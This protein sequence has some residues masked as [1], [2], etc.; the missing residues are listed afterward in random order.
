MAN[1]FVLTAALQLQAPRN[2]NA[3]A[4]AIQNRL[5]NISTNVNIRINANASRNINNINRSITALNATLNTFNQQSSAA[6]TNVTAL[7]NAFRG[8]TSNLNSLNQT[9]T[10]TTRSL[11]GVRTSANDAGDAMERFARSGVNAIKRYASFAAATTGVYALIGAVN[12]GIDEAIKFQ[13]E[14]V[15]ISQVTGTSTKN[16]SGLEKE[17]TRLSTSLGVSSARLVNVSQVLAQAGLSSRE[18]KVGLEA[19]AKTELAATFTNVEKTVEGAI[20]AMQQF[21]IGVEDLENTLG[22]FNTVAGAFAVE[23]DDI[24]TAVRRA[25]AGFSA[26]GGSLN[27]FIALF[28]SVRQTTR[29]S[30]ET[31]ATGFRTIFARIQRPQTIEFFRELGIELTDIKGK[32]IGP[33]ESIRRLSAGLAELDTKDLKFA[34]ITEELG[35][36]RQIQKVIPLIQQFAVAEKALGVAIAGRGSLTRDAAVAQES[37]L[38]QLTKLRE[39][40]FALFRTVGDDAAVQ[41]FGKLMIEMARN[42]V[43]L[44]ESLT[45]LVPLITTIG[46]IK[47]GGALVSLGRGVARRHEGGPIRRFARGGLVPGQGNGDTVPSLLQPG[48]F[49]LTKKAVE[50]IGH[51][52]LAKAN[53]Y[54]SGGA[55][56]IV[57]LSRTAPVNP[58]T[59]TGADLYKNAKK[60]KLPSS[61]ANFSKTY[62]VKNNA[63]FDTPKEVSE[64]LGNIGIDKILKAG[65]SAMS[66][67]IASKIQGNP[68]KA[69]D[70]KDI[71]NRDGIIG[72]LFEGALSAIG[73][74]YGTSKINEQAPFDFPTGLE[75]SGFGSIP[76]DAKKSFTKDT[77]KS[78]TR[79]LIQLTKARHG[80]ELETAFATQTAQSTSAAVTPKLAEALSKLKPGG[81]RFDAAFARRAGYT[82][83]SELE[84]ALG[85]INGYEIT[86]DSN[87]SR[88]I[89]PKLF[90]K[91]GSVGTDTVPAL[92]TPGEFV[93]NKKS[94]QSI[95]YG[96]LNQMN[97]VHKYAA[98]GRVGNVA[99]AGGIGLS[100]LA[101]SILGGIT[102]LGGASKDT[103]E[104]LTRVVQQLGFTAILLGS[105]GKSILPATRDLAA[106]PRRIKREYNFGGNVLG[107]SNRRIDSVN[108]RVNALNSLPPSADPQ[109]TADRAAELSRLRQQGNI[110]NSNVTSRLQRFEANKNRG[111][112]NSVRRSG[113]AFGQGAAVLGSAGAIIGGEFQ[114]SAAEKRLAQGDSSAID[115]FRSGS[116]LSGAGTGAATGAAA[117]SFAG[118]AG[119]AAGALIGGVVGYASA[120]KAADEKAAAI[121]GQSRLEG[122]LNQLG[123]IDSVV[124]L[125]G[126]TQKEGARKRLDL[127][128]GAKTRADEGRDLLSQKN[129]F[130][131]DYQ[132]TD[133]VLTNFGLEFQKRATQGGAIFSDAVGDD[134][135]VRKNAFLSKRTNASASILE[136][137]GLIK[138]EKDFIISQIQE[139]A[140]NSKSVE[141]FNT[142]G[143]QQLNALLGAD[144]LD[145]GELLKVFESQKKAKDAAD[146]LRDSMLAAADEVT[147]F[148]DS[149]NAL[150]SNFAKGSQSLDKAF[151][152]FSGGSIS[153][154][155]SEILSGIDTAI[156]S[157]TIDGKLRQR[158]SL[159][160]SISS[161]FGGGTIGSKRAN[162][163]ADASLAESALPRIIERLKA[164]NGLDDLNE[165][166]FKKELSSAGITDANSVSKLVAGFQ[167][168]FINPNR[169]K[170]DN[171]D[172][173]PETI[174]SI[175]E[176]LKQEADIAKKSLAEQ[177]SYNN[178]LQ[179]VF[180]KRIEVESKNTDITLR[181]IDFQ[182][183]SFKGQK[184]FNKITTGG[185]DDAESFRSARV[186]AIAGRAASVD[187]LGANVARLRARAASIAERAP[188]VAN[189]IEYNKVTAAADRF[190][191][192]LEFAAT[193]TAVLAAKQDE[194]TKAQDER[195]VR[196]GFAKDLAFAGNDGR[197]SIAQD[198]Q[199]AFQVA[200]NPLITG[201]G[202]QESGALKILETF[203]KSPV[204]AGKTGDEVIEARIKGL[205]NQI[206]LQTGL[207]PEAAQKFAK[208]LVQP[209]DKEK[210]LQD[211]ITAEFKKLYD[212]N[213]QIKQLNIDN[214]GRL[215]N[216]TE[217]IANSTAT[218]AAAI[219]VGRVEGAP[220]APEMKAKG[221]SVGY[222]ANGGMFK[223]RGTDTV[224]AMLTPGEFV[225]TRKAAQNIGYD[226]LN[227]LNAM[228]AAGGGP[229]KNKRT[230]AEVLA[231]IRM[232][233]KEKADA[234]KALQ[235]A[236]D[237]ELAKQRNFE[238]RRQR[239]G[240]TGLPLTQQYVQARNEQGITEEQYVNGIKAIRTRAG[241]ANPIPGFIPSSA[242]ERKTLLDEDYYSEAKRNRIANE[243][244][245]PTFDANPFANSAMQ[246]SER[247]DNFIKTVNSNAFGT[248]RST[249]PFN[250]GVVPN[251][252]N[253][254]PSSVQRQTNAGMEAYIKASKEASNKNMD[255]ANKSLEAANKLAAMPQTV[256]HTIKSFDVNFIGLSG[257]IEKALDGGMRKVANAEARRVVIEFMK[258]QFEIDVPRV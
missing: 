114:I 218:M 10:N 57:S 130:E 105:F 38:V 215:V 12:S 192:A 207:S 111:L 239:T 117:L 171:G 193:N 225:V 255:A 128:L 189:T 74:P 25:G 42:A 240:Q 29:E 62:E 210:A 248:P 123:K 33:Y 137:E 125:G 58:I 19:L 253:G 100:L 194:L 223:P 103:A 257:E 200:L 144:A 187:N 21:D 216:N 127:I 26:A 63:L 250:G 245:K 88:Q 157:Q 156:N 185:V 247:I 254:S 197:K 80:A 45:P 179:E 202:E 87:K 196:K 176:F 121:L 167:K 82:K 244:P 53:R 93:I 66:R 230:K 166:D 162:T 78:L 81:T 37:F 85:Q 94:A 22:S 68:I 149:S 136:S 43:K 35:G 183:Q 164:K 18:V 40:F 140:K 246:T 178:K 67:G 106:L 47:L 143:G 5:G 84:K 11:N 134:I 147:K 44:V 76:T 163:I 252:S 64:M 1:G 173:S 195:E 122:A 31:I 238:A 233:N 221:G 217:R 107:N 174:S 219:G 48:E 177:A 186:S 32:F 15:K 51:E 133:S 112:F 234:R 59:V 138:Q 150:I 155:Q 213:E 110:A 236:I 165:D 172:S 169:Q 231:A 91:G 3:V 148:Q 161:S 20:A 97:R 73:G 86:G 201:T 23:S 198:V 188:S 154:G 118:P 135:S 181:Q 175:N 34:Q 98:G 151:A 108:R 153:N 24:V 212:L 227:G 241:D 56:G 203:A 249:T 90:A 129:P 39:E 220:G 206:G 7:S 214:L 109:V 256:E 101:P 228:Y 9:N 83:V 70:V 258:S 146:K 92:L 96:Q 17:I 6:T 30:A 113:G 46:S 54:N 95:G 49:V 232:E 115:S 69:L 251:T 235:P 79:K 209:T 190:A 139:K 224:P 120:I 184:A 229:V 226:T 55:V 182:E 170:T 211:T 126:T 71:P 132:A 116:G 65:I 8:F 199:S 152:V 104:S 28:T 14:L 160:D 36:F 99:N 242:R 61:I 243:K 75:A 119:V 77:K 2:L 191:K 204:F 4:S 124:K 168:A 52:R 180:S 141:E 41:T 237:A 102:D 89:K 50:G 159:R 205:A 27:E 16:L 142:T 208:S 60:G 145:V 222:F 158:N 131:I 13:D 72:G